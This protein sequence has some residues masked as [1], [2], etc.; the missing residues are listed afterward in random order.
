MDSKKVKNFVVLKVGQPL[1]MK[2]PAA[3]TLAVC[4][5]CE[6]VGAGAAQNSAKP[7]HLY[8]S[9]TNPSACK[10]KT[11]NGN[12]WAQV[13]KALDGLRHLYKWQIR[14]VSVEYI[15]IRDISRC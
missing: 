2:L 3:A 12:N 1:Y 9:L 6:R 13:D 8:G 4:P 7:R 14:D 11:Q 15:T 10:P 5:S